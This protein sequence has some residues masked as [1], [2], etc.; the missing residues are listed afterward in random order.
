MV[1][2]DNNLE[3]PED[4]SSINAWVDRNYKKF[5]TIGIFGA[6][7]V[8]LTQIPVK[9]SP[10]IQA[11]IAGSLLIFSLLTILVLFDGVE[12]TLK[13]ANRSDPDMILFMLIIFSLVGILM[14]VVSILSEFSRGATPL[15]DW[16]TSIGFALYYF[17][18]FFSDN[19]FDKIE[20][21]NKFRQAIKYS[22]HISG[23]WII[24]ADL[25]ERYQGESTIIGQTSWDPV[26]FGVFVLIFTHFLLMLWIV[27]AF[28]TSDFIINKVLPPL[29]NIE[30]R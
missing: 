10:R 9:T 16:A 14:A 3:E 5:T 18:F 27:V 24:L 4:K 15:I 20:P 29:R 12:E 21:K 13:L 22:P 23:A 2:K 28:I 7:S 17:T 25:L 6:L 1:E 11:G 26:I 8:Y 19:P 30:V